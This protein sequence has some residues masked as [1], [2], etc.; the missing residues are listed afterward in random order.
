MKSLKIK[1]KLYQE[2]KSK[3]FIYKEM[4]GWGNF[5]FL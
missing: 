5:W 3:G 4:C 1:R 2:E